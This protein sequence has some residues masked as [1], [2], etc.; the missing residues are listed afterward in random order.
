MH[1][2]WFRTTF[3]RLLKFPQIKEGYLI[4]WEGPIL[5]NDWIIWSPLLHFNFKSFKGPNF[6]PFIRFPCILHDSGIP[7]PNFW[8]LYKLKR[9]DLISW[10]ELILQNGWIIWSPLLHFNCKSFKDPNSSSF[11]RF[12]CILHDSRVPFL[13]FWNFYKLKRGDLISWG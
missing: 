10:G 12:E 1:S 8:N 4:S 5:Q 13:D 9:G 6:S 3:L 11:V 7:F 2:A